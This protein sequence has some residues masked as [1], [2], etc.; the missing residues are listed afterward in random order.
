MIINASTIIVTVIV[1]SAIGFGGLQLIRQFALQIAVENFEA[2]QAMDEKEEKSRKK[3]IAL[4]D[5]A[6]SS[7][8]Q[9]VEPLIQ[10]NGAGT[11]S[12][13]NTPPAGIEMGNSTI[14]SPTSAGV[15]PSS[16]EVKKEEKQK[17]LSSDIV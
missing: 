14:I 10:K 15:A 16:A 13:P 1:V 17:L 3:K 6:A 12:R 7:A 8:F 2:N 9:K 4:A 5:A 11:G